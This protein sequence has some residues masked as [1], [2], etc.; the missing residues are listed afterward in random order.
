MSSVRRHDT[1]LFR[2]TAFA[3]VLALATAIVLATGSAASAAA[4]KLPKITKVTPLTN[5][6]IGTKISVKGKNFVKGKKT[7]VVI[8]KR[9][10][11]KRKFTARGDASSSTRATI[12]VPD[13][14]G[15]L[16][17]AVPPATLNPLA[18]L[19]RLR[20][21]TKFGAA[22][23][24]T[25]TSIS[26]RISDSLI[27][28]PTDTGAS[29]DCDKDGIKNS[30]DTDDDGDLL[31]DTIELT[32]GTD[33]C[34][35]DTD[36]DTISDFYEYTVAYALN[37]GPTLP[38]P[39][40]KPFP[41]PLVPDNGDYDNDKLTT[42]QE[43]D[44][45]QYTGQMSHFY[46]DAD[47][48]SDGD[49]KLDPAEDED[50]DLLPNHIESYGMKNLNWLKTDTDGDGLCDGL[51]D[52]DHDGPPT[53]LAIAD[54]TT[55]VPNNG[56][57]PAF[58]PTDP[59]N[60]VPGGDPDPLKIDGDDNRYSNFYEWYNEG[61]DPDV[62]DAMYDECVPSI[63]PVSPFCHIGHDWDPFSIP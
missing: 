63:Y 22:K 44:A 49:G 9:D 15:D 7:L 8:F 50:H 18:N 27:S 56:P 45:W 10:G 11:S 21:I 61:A 55:R 39:G 40:L 46:S 43:Y 32:I 53:P 36:L 17:R 58:P 6:V 4:S 20:P 35:T 31:D 59:F 34:R 3:F 25:S 51:D 54:C 19:Y 23:A 28:L 38:Y 41:N 37:G 29:G 47:G 52:Q 48:D 13:L 60:T 24:W 30:A 2:A 26:P 62:A 57:L 12:V 14:T 16:E 1:Q 33:V 5:V 42:Q